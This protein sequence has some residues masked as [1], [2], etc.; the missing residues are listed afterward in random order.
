MPH[1]LAALAAHADVEHAVGEARAMVD[2]LLGHRVLRRRSAEVA[3]EMALRGA[4]ASA[5]LDGSVHELAALREGASVTDP[6]LLAALRL[7]LEVAP[8]TEVV[9]RAPAQALARLHAVA[10]ADAVPVQRVGRP[11]V[12]DERV[13]DPL[14]LGDPP[15]AGEVAVRMSALSELLTA[16]EPVAALVLAAVVHGEVLALRPFGWGN[17]LVARAAARLLLVARG[18][19]PKAVTAPDVGHAELAGA[20]AERAAGYADGTPDGVVAWVVHCAEAV[21]LGAREG[22]ALCEAMQRG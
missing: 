4:R 7:S 15:P 19:D 11:R 8:L 18:L 21:R 16:R 3:A 5:A 6:V 22:V 10:A 9:G 20:Y 17:G 1:P 12:E 13:T 2:R 14:G